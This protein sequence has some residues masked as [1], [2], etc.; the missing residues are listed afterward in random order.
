[1]GRRDEEKLVNGCKI[2]VIEKKYV[3]VLAQSCDYG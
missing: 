2:M 1:M 3:L